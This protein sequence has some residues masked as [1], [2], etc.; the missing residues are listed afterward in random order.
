MS[1]NHKGSHKLDDTGK[2]K[3]DA[4]GLGGKPSRYDELGDGSEETA[5]NRKNHWEQW[6]KH[7]PKLRQL[8]AN[9]V[10]AVF[11]ESQR[12]ISSLRD[13]QVTIFAQY[14]WLSV[15][16]VEIRCRNNWFR[17]TYIVEHVR[18]NGVLLIY[19]LITLE[20]KGNVPPSPAVLKLGA[21]SCMFTL[22]S[23]GKY[24]CLSRLRP[25]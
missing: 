6:R 13:V 9:D 12:A 8:N 20:R 10:D 3:V 22:D 14:L 15:F 5:G 21:I 17:S 16:G 2:R 1:I 4:L 19:R 18:F 11:A 7:P 23:G 24:R 25:P